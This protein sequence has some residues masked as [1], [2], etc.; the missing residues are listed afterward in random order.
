MAV[1]VNQLFDMLN[2]N[3][4][5]ETQK[6]G[7]EEGAKVKYLSVF[8]L[9]TESKGL[10]ENCAKILAAK[11]DQE[12]M[13]YLM[14]IFEWF[15]DANWPGFEIIYNRFKKIPAKCIFEAYEFTITRALS[16]QKD[17]G[18][19]WLTYLSG[20]ITNREL[21]ELLPQDKQILMKKY[22]DR[23]WKLQEE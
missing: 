6:K 7:L 1:D 11:T 15:I 2:W 23:W 16:R 22:Y 18:E 17:D 5:E 14:V 8:I 12:I 9:P 20:L 13:P 10:W 19:M 3:R 21:F 4:D